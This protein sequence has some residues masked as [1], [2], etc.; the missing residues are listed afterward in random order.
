MTSYVYL[1]LAA[2][3]GFFMPVQAAINSQLGQK[4][5]GPILASAVSFFVGTICLFAF[6][7]L[8]KVSMPTLTVLQSVPLKLYL[9]G[10][11]GALFV[12]FITLLIPKL[13]AAT[14]VAFVLGG[15]VTTSLIL[16]HLGLL[17]LPQHSLSMPRILGGVL[18]IVGIYL[19]RRF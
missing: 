16:D 13:G 8:S 15:Q 11:I 10:V 3:A 5:G 4:I 18:I 19:I 2:L 6:L 9:G 1:M 14:M 7:L 12:A 17:G